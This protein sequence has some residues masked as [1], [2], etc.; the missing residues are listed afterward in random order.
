MRLWLRLTLVMAALTLVPLVVTGSLA[1]RA[2]TENAT[3]RPEEQMSRDASTLAIFTGM[4]VDAQARTMAG[5]QRVWDVRARSEDHQLGLIRAVWQAMDHT[6][7]VALVD[8]AGQPVVPA[9]YLTEN[10]IMGAREA[11]SPARADALLAHIPRRLNAEG[12]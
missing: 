8:E 3:L 10:Q 6:V 1:V 5:W 12:F 2:S 7:T 4:W 9:V 11:G